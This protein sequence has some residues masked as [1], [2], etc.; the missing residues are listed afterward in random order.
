MNEMCWLE[1]ERILNRIGDLFGKGD[2]FT[3]LFEQTTIWNDDLR[4]FPQGEGT[5]HAHLSLNL[6][7]IFTPDFDNPTAVLFKFVE[8]ELMR[9]LWASYAERSVVSEFFLVISTD[10]ENLGWAFRGARDR[11]VCFLRMNEVIVSFLWTK[12]TG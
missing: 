12:E 5:F 3:I 4:A 11:K 2:Y 7:I 1:G 10:P 8:N 9:L 6:Y